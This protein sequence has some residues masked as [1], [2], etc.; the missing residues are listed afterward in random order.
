MAFPRSRFSDQHYRLI[1]VNVAAFGQLTDPG[2]RDLWRLREIEPFP[3]L[4]SRHLRI[5]N[6]VIDRV[7]A[8]LF[9]IGHPQQ[10]RNG[11]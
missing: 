7:P 10:M 3:R 5:A 4:Q 2:R 6:P 11:G 1:A 8:A 9:G